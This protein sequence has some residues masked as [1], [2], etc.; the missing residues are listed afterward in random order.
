MSRLHGQKKWNLTDLKILAGCMLLHAEFR[1]IWP[2][3]QLRH[4]VVVPPSDV[5]T[6]L[7]AGVQ[8]ST[9][10]FL[11]LSN[12]LM[13]T[14]RSQTLPFKVWRTKNKHPIFR[15]PGGVRSSSLI[16]ILSMVIEDVCAIF[17]SRKRICIRRIVSPLGGGV[18]W[19]KCTFESKLP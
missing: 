19:A 9:L 4:S 17:A 2:Y 1:L 3:F 10:P 11:M 6:K 14:S 16:I 7:N 13:A 8:Q 12:G 5:E 15:H 18:I